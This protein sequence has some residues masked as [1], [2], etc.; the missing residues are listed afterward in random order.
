MAQHY[1][2]RIRM[3]SQRMATLIRDLLD[4]S[5]VAEMVRE[6]VDLSALAGEMVSDLRGRDP[7]RAAEI[8]ADGLTVEGDRHL[9]RIALCR[10]CSKTRGVY[11]DQPQRT[12]RAGGHAPRRRA[13]DGVRPGGTVFYVA[14]TWGSTWLTPA[15]CSTLFQRLHATDAFPGTGIGLVTVRRIVTRHGGRVWAEAERAEGPRSISPREEA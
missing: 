5:R 13:P 7:D 6:R 2:E 10:T 1:L 9:W 12:N 8:I 14:T 4:L 15:S 3:A 11:G